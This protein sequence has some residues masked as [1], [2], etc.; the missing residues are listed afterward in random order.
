MKKLTITEL[1]LENNWPKEMLKA[2]DEF[3]IESFVSDKKIA[4]FSGGERF[5]YRF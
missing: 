2:M 3:G 4:V 5:K 1:F